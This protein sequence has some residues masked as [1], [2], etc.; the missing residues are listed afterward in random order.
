M[1]EVESRSAT[2]HDVGP[3]RDGTLSVRLEV[4]PRSIGLSADGYGVYGASEGD[5]TPVLIELHEGELRVIV[6]ADINREEPT[7]IIPLGGAREAQ[8]HPE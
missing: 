3:G 1:T 2:L 6:F 4:S 5:G 7:H 8:R